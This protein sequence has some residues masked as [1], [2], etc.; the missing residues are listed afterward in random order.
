MAAGERKEI[1]KMK[2]MARRAMLRDLQEMLGLTG[3]PSK[4]LGGNNLNQMGPTPKRGRKTM[5]PW[6]FR[7]K[8][9]SKTS[10]HVQQ[11]HCRHQPLRRLLHPSHR[12]PRCF[13]ATNRS[14]IPRLRG[15]PSLRSNHKRQSLGPPYAA[16]GLRFQPPSRFLLRLSR[17]QTI[18]A[19]STRIP[20]QQ[21]RCVITTVTT[22]L[23]TTGS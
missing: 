3:V 7:R 15:P 6:I 2:K 5:K 20:E 16:P 23:P 19:R 14:P 9:S 17:L 1:R 11:S 22:I 10:L 12:S 18:E 8:L 4:N 21:S 13:G